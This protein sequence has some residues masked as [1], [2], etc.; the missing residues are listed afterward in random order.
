MATKELDAAATEVNRKIYAALNSLMAACGLVGENGTEILFYVLRDAVV[1][2]QNEWSIV[3]GSHDEGLCFNVNALLAQQ[4]EEALA[5]YAK[6]RCVVIGHI[7]Q[8][9]HRNIDAT[10]EGS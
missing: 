10:S 3:E 2:V 1:S 6:D 9:D 8:C 7:L 4:I 5:Q